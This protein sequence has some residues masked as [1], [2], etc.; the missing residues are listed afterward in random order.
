[1]SL[2]ERNADVYKLEAFRQ[3]IVKDNFTS[4][5]RMMERLD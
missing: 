2:R 4:K 1:V 3:K 5:T